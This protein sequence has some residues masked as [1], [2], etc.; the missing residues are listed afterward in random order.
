MEWKSGK[1]PCRPESIPAPRKDEQFGN[2][3]EILKGD[4]NAVIPMNVTLI[5]MA[6]AGKS[7][8][9]K[10]LAKKLRLQFIDVDRDLWEATYRKPIQ[11]IL[12]E[13]GEKWYVDEEERLI[14]EHTKGKDGLLISPPGSV[15][16]QP[17][18]MEHLKENTTI[19][20]LKVPYET[21]KARLEGTPPRAIIGLGRKTLRELYDERHPLYERH[22]DIIIETGRHRT[23]QTI[24]KIIEFLSGKTGV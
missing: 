19:V 4:G 7:Y 13:R 8:V 17:K 10:R 11:E 14:I 6:G 3:W 2:T 1:Y 24:Q 9:G 5:G 12:D 15:V 18:A 20:Y 16:Y 22:A 23:R 21:I